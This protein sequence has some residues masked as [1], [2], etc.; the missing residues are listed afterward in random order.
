[1][2]LPSHFHETRLEV[3]HGLMRAHPL[4]TLVTQGANGLVANHFPLEIDADAS[5]H[6]T[7]R[8]HMAR[9]NPAW[10]EHPTGTEVLVIFQGP[11]AYVSP[12][13]Y[14]SKQRD[15]RVVPTW[16]YAVVHAY[17]ALRTIED[18]TWLRGLVGRLTATYEAA[19]RAP[20]KVEDAPVDFIDRM[21]TAIVGFEIPITRVE[22]KWKMSQ[23]RPAEDRA[24]VAAGLPTTARRC[25]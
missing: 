5:P 18:A 11:H 2:Y 6:G 15:G 13:W 3:L 4:A 24:G 20:W 12:S 1:M 14:P 22:G 7:L 8:G 17:G 23:N 16:N 10:R 21:L 9:A 25:R 19:Q